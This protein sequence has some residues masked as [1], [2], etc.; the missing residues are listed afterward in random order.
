VKQRKKQPAVTRQAILAAAGEGFAACG[1]AA[2]GLGDIGSRAGLTKGALFHHFPDK[3]TLAADW[4][5]SEVRTGIDAEWIGPLDEIRS[6]DALKSFCRS[7]CLDLGTVDPLSALV[8]ITAETAHAE[9]HLREASAGVFTA[10]RQSFADLISRGKSDG[11]I[12]RSIQP[13][14]EAAFIVSSVAGLTV[15]AKAD[16]T[17]ATR[18]AGADALGAYLETLRSQ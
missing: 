2:T 15:T 11:W 6:L 18:R 7:R 16:P 13:A 9:P 8:A 1:Y 12:H 4:I 14:S 10:L 17:D 5:T 3:R